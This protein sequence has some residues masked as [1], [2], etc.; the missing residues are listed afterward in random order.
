[1][2]DFLARLV[3][4][5]G[6]ACANH[7]AQC[8]SSARACARPYR[9]GARRATRGRTAILAIGAVTFT[10]SVK[11]GKHIAEIGGYRRLVLE[12]G[13]NDP[14]IVMEDAD[15]DKAADLAVMGA[16]KNSGQRCTAIKRNLVVDS[17][18]ARFVEKILPRAEGT[19]KKQ[20]YA[21][22]RWPKMTSPSGAESPSPVGPFL[23][24][25]QPPPIFY[26]ELCYREHG[27]RA[28]LKQAIETNLR[29]AR[30][31]IAGFGL[32]CEEFPLFIRVEELSEQ[33]QKALQGL[34]RTTPPA[35]LETVVEKVAAL[36]VKADALQ[37]DTQALKLSIP[38]TLNGQT[39]AIN[40]REA[41]IARL[42]TALAASDV[43]YFRFGQLPEPTNAPP[44]P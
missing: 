1:V 9:T 37:S 17:V 30:N 20:G 39:S 24:W 33:Y 3:R 34:D 19:A 25:Q 14:L 22:A 7:G 21:G 32:E 18:A 23:V 40:E 26:A 11:V 41:E 4:R 38:A 8:R 35:T 36:H 12:L 44:K 16:T 31:N 13:G 42:K 10:G 29:W 28:T 6:S 2:V 15:L 27:A 43:R 5:G